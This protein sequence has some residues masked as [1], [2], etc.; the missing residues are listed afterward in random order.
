MSLLSNPE[1]RFLLWCHY[2]SVQY[3][4]YSCDVL[5]IFPNTQ[6]TPV[7]P[8]SFRPLNRLLMSYT[9]YFCHYDPDQY[10]DCSCDAIMIQPN[11]QITHVMSL[12]SITPVMSLH[13][14][15]YADYSCVVTLIQ[16]NTQITPVLSLWSSPIHRLLLS[17]WSRPTHRSL[18]CY[19]YDPAQQIDY[20]C[21]YDP[22]QYTDYSCP[23]YVVQC[24]CKR[25]Y[26]ALFYTEQWNQFTSKTNKSDINHLLNYIDWYQPIVLL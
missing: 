4:D 14:A 9:E 16:P 10:T 18:L 25:Q 21:N 17:L 20:F 11:S 23:V 19:H 12:S 7:M 8:L 13:P 15:Q 22:V 3:I 2:D 26:L 1:H 24:V 6:I 5:I